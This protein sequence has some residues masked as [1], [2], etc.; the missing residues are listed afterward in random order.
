VV[1]AVMAAGKVTVNMSSVLNIMVQIEAW[2]KTN[3]IID[4]R[5]L[6]HCKFSF[7]CISS[8]ILTVTH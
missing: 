5:F 8:C 2:N 6:Q 1:P 3:S 4:F 7:T